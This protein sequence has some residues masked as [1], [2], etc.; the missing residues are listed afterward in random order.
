MCSRLQAT[1]VHEHINWDAA[2]NQWVSGH[3]NETRFSDS[4]L[5]YSYHICEY[6]LM[7]MY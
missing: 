2:G 1:C 5:H 7:S 6:Y 3:I 4:K